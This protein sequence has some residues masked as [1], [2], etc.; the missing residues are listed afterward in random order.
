MANE[1]NLGLADRNVKPDLFTGESPIESAHKT[2]AAVQKDLAYAL[3]S[4][5]HRSWTH[6]LNISGA[7]AYSVTLTAPTRF[8][9]S[10]VCLL[11]TS[12]SPRDAT[13]SRMPSSA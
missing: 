2:W 8:I 10:K 13:L 4:N 11:Y 1:S 9:A 5:V 7:D 3:G 6:R 12:P